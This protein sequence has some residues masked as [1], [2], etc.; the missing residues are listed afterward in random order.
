MSA[1][2]SLTSLAFIRLGSSQNALHFSNCFSQT[3]KNEKFM[4]MS[5]KVGPISK[6]ALKW[7]KK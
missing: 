2:G 7:F 5:Q 1:Q 4:S 6:D 3:T